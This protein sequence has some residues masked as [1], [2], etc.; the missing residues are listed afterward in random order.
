MQYRVRDP[1]TKLPTLLVFDN[2]AGG[3]G[4]SER[5]FGSALISATSMI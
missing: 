5:V 4:L 3:I 1:F 2:Y